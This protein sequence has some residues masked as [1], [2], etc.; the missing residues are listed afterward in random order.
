MDDD[1]SILAVNRIV[2]RIGAGDFGT[3]KS[4]S[5][6]VCVCVC[7]RWISKCPIYR[8]F[9]Y[10]L[11]QVYSIFRKPYNLFQKMLQSKYV[12]PDW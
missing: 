8:V 10:L 12:K 1:H 11:L 4:M 6:C 3:R 9:I 2:W 5:P 7:V